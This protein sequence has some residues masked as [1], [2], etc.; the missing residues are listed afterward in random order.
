MRWFKKKKKKVGKRIYFKEEDVEDVIILLDNFRSAP[1][2]KDAHPRYLLWKH[3]FKLIPE[4]KNGE[5]TLDHIG[6]TQYYIE[7]EVKQ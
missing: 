5:W 4:A 2:N 1:I 7:Q 6:A 3:I